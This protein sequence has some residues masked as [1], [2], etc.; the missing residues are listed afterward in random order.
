[1]RYDFTRCSISE[2]GCVLW[3]WFPR[4]NHFRG[5]GSLPVA[6]TQMLLIKRCN[7]LLEKLLALLE[8]SRAINPVLLVFIFKRKKKMRKGNSLHSLLCVPSFIARIT[9]L[10]KRVYAIP[11]LYVPTMCQILY[12]AWQ[13]PRRCLPALEEQCNITLLKNYSHN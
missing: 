13:T 6:M 2:F 7:H 11:Q 8:L 9:F 4:A 3:L 12:Q 5:F 1:M 10:V